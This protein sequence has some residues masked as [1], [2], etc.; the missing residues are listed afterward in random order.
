MWYTYIVYCLLHVSAGIRQSYKEHVLTTYKICYFSHRLYTLQSIKANTQ[1]V[2]LS[3]GSS[4]GKIELDNQGH[5]VKCCI[6]LPTLMPCHETWSS[7][8]C[9]YLERLVHVVNAFCWT[10]SVSC[11]SCKLHVVMED[12]LP[13]IV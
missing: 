10:K 5:W 11:N 6:T 4:M 2:S 9:I 8:S 1:S 3:L 12:M 7:V 13:K